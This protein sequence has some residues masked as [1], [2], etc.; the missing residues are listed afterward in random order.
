MVLQQELDAGH[1]SYRLQGE[2]LQQDW[3]AEL[4]LDG[5][6]SFVPNTENRTPLKVLVLYGSLRRRS[7]S[8]LLAFEFARRA[9]QLHRGAGVFCQRD[10]RCALFLRSFGTDIFTAHRILDGLGADARVFDPEG[11]PMKDDRSEEH[12]K[13]QELRGLSLWSEAH[14][15]VSPEQHGTLT[16]VFKNQIDWIPLSLGS[17]R[18]SQGRTLAVAQV[19]NFCHAL[20]SPVVMT[21]LHPHCCTC[22]RGCPVVQASAALLCSLCCR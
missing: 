1:K 21:R 5:A 19:R 9:Y 18:P 13:V 10:P 16:A 4:E 20:L 22:S 12:P 14:V 6:R 3:V 2:A 11:L 7:Y 8:Q 17:V 15:W